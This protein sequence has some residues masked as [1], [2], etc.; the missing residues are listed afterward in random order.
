MSTLDSILSDKITEIPTRGEKEVQLVEGNC[1]ECG[2]Q[3][4]VVYCEQC[5]DDYCQVCFAH[6]HRKGNRKLHTVVKKATAETGGNDKVQV[7]PNLGL[8]TEDDDLV[9]SAQDFLSQL[10]D[11][12]STGSTVDYVEKCKFIPLR[13]TFDERRLLKLLEAALS[14]SSYTD[15]IDIITYSK[16]TTRIVQQIKELL[17]I[18]AGLV[19][20]NDYKTGQ[21]LF[22]DKEFHN[23]KEFYQSVFEIGRR[24]KIMNPEKMRDGYGKLVYMLQDSQIEQVYELLQFKCVKPILTVHSVL[25]EH[26]K[27]GLLQDELLPLAT[28]EI[29]D[30]GRKRKEIQYDIKRKEKAIEILAKKYSTRDLDSETVK[31]CLYSIGDN[32]AFL[33][34]NRDP[35][36]AMIGYFY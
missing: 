6:Q 32:N 36:I 30:G 3:P 8:Q 33:R 34:V 21:L 25:E 1:I 24:H 35:C 29:I 11:T 18:L 15:K 9:I 19:L 7:K 12:T 2:D 20:A 13:L 17:G 16:K 27:L 31:Q 4:S 26:G 23:N 28:S 14:V 22:Q 5:S 10:V